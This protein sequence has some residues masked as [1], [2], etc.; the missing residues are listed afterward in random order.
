[1][2]QLC[3]FA[4]QGLHLLDLLS[5]F[6][7]VENDYSDHFRLVVKLNMHYFG[8]NRDERDSDKAYAIAAQFTQ[9]LRDLGFCVY[10][11]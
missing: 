10:L 1:V 5:E 9:R 7:I 11:L 3:A 4:Q 8:V 6:G 2:P